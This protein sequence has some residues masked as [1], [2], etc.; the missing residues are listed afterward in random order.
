MATNSPESNLR[1]LSFNCWGLKY[2][3]KHR[4]QRIRA[5]AVALEKAQYDIVGLQELWVFADYEHIRSKL[6][7]AMPYS[8]FFHSGALGS[9]LAIFSKFPI[10]SAYVYPYSLN[11]N[12][13]DVISGD[14]FVGKA[15]ASV[16][17]SHPVLGLLEILNTH[18]HAKGGEDG[19]EHHRAHRLA[20]A[21]EFSRLICQ[22]SERGRHV[23]AMGDL[24]STPHTLPIRLIT[25]L[26]GA[27]DAW[28]VTHPGLS[29]LPDYVS[30]PMEAIFERGVTCDS[31]LSIYTQGKPLGGYAK[32][33]LGKRLDYILYRGSAHAN[34]RA[35]MECISSEV[36]FFEKD[37]AGL[38]LSDHFAVDA[39]FAINRHNDPHP[40]LSSVLNTAPPTVEETLRAL[41]DHYRESRQRSHSYMV[42]FSVCILFLLGITV[43][44]AWLPQ[45][46][47]NPIFIILAIAVAWF[48]TTLL[49]VGFVF[50]RW[51]AN[52]L[53][54]VMEELELFK[55]GATGSSEPAA[56]D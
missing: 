52:A 18:F 53:T 24:N 27:T 47:I 9:G 7:K 16:L 19:P 2:V 3:A 51:E 42:T 37:S 36:R 41:F 45:P 6:L 54:N 21:W 32:R 8:K 13:I 43:G 1:V 10:Q 15:A 17:L 56:M 5:I 20:N 55:A 4:V 29:A 50:G 44:S 12:P 40:E 22:A 34:R 49:Y 28:L 35:S 25:D 38:S 14:W 46:W 33:Y 31:P 26:T 48:A 23:I 11:G 30:S 39:A